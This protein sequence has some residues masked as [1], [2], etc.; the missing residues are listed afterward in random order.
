MNWWRRPSVRYGYDAL[1]RLMEAAYTLDALDEERQ[2]E[3]VNAL[4]R[5]RLTF[6][7]DRLGFKH[8][9]RAALA[10][11]LIDFRGAELPDWFDIGRSPDLGAILPLIS[12][13]LEFVFHRDL[14]SGPRDW[15]DGWAC[16]DSGTGRPGDGDGR[17]LHP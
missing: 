10:S 17:R 6:A 4:V 14:W 12:A 7:I 16:A 5:E 9:D 2:M 3:I 13:N 15:P 11:L 8:E 1:A